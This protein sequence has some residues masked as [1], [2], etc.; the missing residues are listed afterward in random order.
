MRTDA[1]RKG[2]AG[3]AG[4]ANTRR[5]LLAV[6]GAAVLLM[7][8]P[9]QAATAVIEEIRSRHPGIAVWWAGNSG[10]LIKSN[11]L[12]I[13]T[14]LDLESGDKVQPPPVTAQELAP[15]LDVLF[16]THHHGDHCNTATIRVLAQGARCSFVLPQPCLK[17]VAKLGIPKERILVPEPGHPFEIKGIRVEPIHAIHGNQEFTVLTRER[18]FLDSMAHN[19]GYVFNIAG[20]RLLQPGDSLLTEEHLTL[21]N[22]DVLFV[23]PTVHNMY[24]DRSMILINRLQPAY[25]FPQH[26]GTYAETDENSFWTRGY[27]DELKARL[28]QELQKRY[29]KLKP[30]ELFLIR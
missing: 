30:G 28:S 29:H 19:C 25:V 11:D 10:W 24:I 21:A 18:D 15:V 23:S 2:A 22:I 17:A 13:A 4:T 16:V 8:L 26:F 27:P 12:L 7:T 5:L 20:K 3:A 6:A 1:N 14:D 9:V